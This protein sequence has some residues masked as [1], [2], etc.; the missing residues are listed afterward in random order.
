MMLAIQRALESTPG[1]TK[2]FDLDAVFGQIRQIAEGAVDVPEVIV[3]EARRTQRKLKP[4]SFFTGFVSGK[5]ADEHGKFNFYMRKASSKLG[6]D[7]DAAIGTWKYRGA[8]KYRLKRLPSAGT[9]GLKALIREGASLL[10]TKGWAD[11]MARRAYREA[12]ALEDKL[13]ARGAILTPRLRAEV[14]IGRWSN[15][16]IR[17]DFSVA[18]VEAGRLFDLAEQSGDHDIRVVACRTLGTN[19][20]WHGDFVAADEHLRTCLEELARGPEYQ[21]FET[22]LGASPHSFACADLADA[23]W[24]LGRYEEALDMVRLARDRALEKTDYFHY[25]YALTFASWIQFKLGRL[26]DAA[27][28]SATLLEW[29]DRCGL[30]AFQALGSVLNGMIRAYAADDAT[31][32]IGSIYA[33]LGAW[34]AGGAEL[35]VCYFF[36]D[37]AQAWLRCGHSHAAELELQKAFD[38]AK[39][40]G[41]GYYLAEMHRL[42]GDIKWLHHEEFAEAEV[43]LRKSL[44]IAT[45]QQ[46]KTF[47]LRAALSLLKLAR[48]R[49]DIPTRRKK[50]D[51]ANQERELRTI[52][53][54]FVSVPPSAELSEAQFLLTDPDQS[55]ARG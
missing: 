36:A 28:E 5:K 31:E 17:G 54:S 16:L 13:I 26:D 9:E 25:C 7:Y 21:P 4:E 29:A 38:V 37:A 24:A 27:R 12:R 8:L 49:P 20:L 42:L 43:D 44:E 3:Q 18:K 34:R 35:L 51:I 14:A 32:G 45:A 1:H 6:L 15:S 19:A 30:A 11:D 50:R 2:S 48:E 10:A 46:S 53:D 41:E 39:K 55:R 22:D 47:Q 23:L 52:C 40:T 33:G